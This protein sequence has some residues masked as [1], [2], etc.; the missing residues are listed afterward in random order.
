M[1]LLDKKAPDTDK[2]KLSCWLPTFQQN[3]SVST[4]TS[5]GVILTKIKKNIY[6]YIYIYTIHPYCAAFQFFFHFDLVIF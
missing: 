3:F 2:V 1:K 6:I 4:D 5:M